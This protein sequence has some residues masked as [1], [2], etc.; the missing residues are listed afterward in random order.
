MRMTRLRAAPLRVP[1]I[2][3]LAVNRVF[4][5]AVF[6]FALFAVNVGNRPAFVAQRFA[7]FV[8]QIQLRYGGEWFSVECVERF[9]AEETAL[10]RLIKFD[11]LQRSSGCE[12]TG[13]NGLC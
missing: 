1:E 4:R 5:R 7:R 2:C 8:E 3:R 12:R 11:F 13:V 9:D 10:R 6:L